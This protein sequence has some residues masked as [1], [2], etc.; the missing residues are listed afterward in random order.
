MNEQQA[1]VQ[2]LSQRSPQGFGMTQAPP[3]GVPPPGPTRPPFMLGKQP[4]NLGALAPVAEI[5][6]GMLPGSGDV[7]AARD[8]QAAGQAMVDALRGGDYGR[9]ASSGLEAL[10]HGLGAL[11]MI[12][13]FGSMVKA[14][15]G[16]PH[17]FDA[18]DMS[19]IGTGEGAQAYGHGLYFAENPSIA[20]HYKDML[21][22][23]RVLIDG[24]EA[25]GL[26]RY[27]A[28]DLLRDPDQTQFKISAQRDHIKAMEAKKAEIQAGNVD[29][30]SPWGA[31]DQKWDW[32]DEDMLSDAK[33]HVDAMERLY[34]SNVKI[35]Q[36]GALYN[37]SLD[38]EPEDLLD[39]DAPLSQQSEQFRNAWGGITKQAT[40]AQRIER[41][42]PG[43]GVRPGQR[44]LPGVPDLPA[45]ATGRDM[46]VWLSKR[47]GSDQAASRALGEA[48]IPGLRYFDAGSRG[49]G[50]GSR[51]VV[52][53]RD[54]LIKIE[55]VE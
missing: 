15:H 2:L 5:G 36:G 27:A 13:A 12:P 44:H 45:D 31:I 42:V 51:N 16:S 52:M 40:D 23:N 3:I 11:P 49:K 20:G 8:S 25:T 46:Y 26:D 43:G 19:K 34:K 4:M 39:W 50:E 55:G 37:V 1:L 10:G 38:V 53:W 47:L 54:D 24:K 17:R 32:R 9:A 14:F 41:P 29:P 22:T 21:G 7:M 18:F 48:G 6:L 33:A 35:E 30:N 28:L